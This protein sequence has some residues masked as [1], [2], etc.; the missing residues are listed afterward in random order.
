MPGLER[1]VNA[2]GASLPAAEP[3]DSP[4]HAALARAVASWCSDVIEK[5]G[6]RL[7]PQELAGLAAVRDTC[8]ES[9]ACDR[10][11]LTALRRNFLAYIANR[12]DANT[13]PHPPEWWAAKAWMLG[14]APKQ[15]PGSIWDMPIGDSTR[16]ATY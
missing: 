3:A 12:V 4:D 14:A 16:L 8:T 9:A 5:D 2:L 10:G 15:Q 13:P 6:H 1:R 11:C 7:T